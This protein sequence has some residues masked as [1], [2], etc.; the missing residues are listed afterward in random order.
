LDKERRDPMKRL[1]AITVVML[2]S[3][4][5]FFA[6]VYAGPGPVTKPFKAKWTGT[7]YTVGLC[8][9]EWPPTGNLVQ[10][11][12]VGKGV[13]TLTG[14]SDFLFVYCIDATYGVGSGWGIL[15]AASGDTIHV[16][17]EELAVDLTKDPVEWSE[18][19]LILGGTGRFEGAIGSSF[20]HGTWT[21]GTD[22]FPGTSIPPPLLEAPQGWVGTT[23]G[24][25][26]Y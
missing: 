19:E 26:T 9:D 21:S 16:S 2:L 23:E 18:T 8:F 17:V 14:V 6:V 7:L 5:M 22:S 13:S 10:T 20:S 3:S 4:A 15:T 12:N 11:I 24:E 1:F 25:V